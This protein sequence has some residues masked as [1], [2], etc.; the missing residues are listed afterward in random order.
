MILITLCLSV[1]I[2]S[3]SDFDVFVF[4]VATCAVCMYVCEQTKEIYK[5]RKYLRVG[6]PCWCSVMVMGVGTFVN[7]TL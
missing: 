6:I 5:E 3:V 2:R 4:R 7:I 1:K